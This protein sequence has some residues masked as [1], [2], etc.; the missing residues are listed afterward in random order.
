[1]RVQHGMHAQ[2]C[3]GSGMTNEFQHE[4]VADQRLA[5]PI[6]RDEREELVF[7]GIP[8]GSSGRIMTDMHGQASFVGEVLQGDFPEAA[9]GSIA[10]ATVCQDESFLG[11][12]IIWLAILQP[13]LADGFHGEGGRAMIE[14]D[15]DEALLLE[16]ILDPVGDGLDPAFVFILFPKIMDIDPAG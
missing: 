1:M 10:A 7:D 3:F 15:T 6:D 14:A 4:F 9:F 8:F 5:T 13:V 12:G 16:N 11:I 2:A